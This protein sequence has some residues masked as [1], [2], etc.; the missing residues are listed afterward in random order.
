MLVPDLA[1]DLG[2]VS[3]GGKTYTFTLKDGIKFGPPLNREITSK[4]VLWAFERIGTKSVAAQYGFYYDA[5]KGM[6]AFRDG[7]SKV[8][9]GIKTPDPK[10]IIFTLTQA[11][12]RLPLPPRACRPPARSRRRS[13]DASRSRTSTAA[14]SSPRART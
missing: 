6:P 1:T 3:N 13:R 4:D 2:K 10:T 9:A 7:K 12:G 5:I 14:T 8:I 11:H